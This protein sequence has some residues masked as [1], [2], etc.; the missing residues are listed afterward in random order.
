[1]TIM[2]P[3][4]KHVQSKNTQKAYILV[5]KSIKD[6]H[7]LMTTR[8]VLKRSKIDF[9]TSM[10]RIWYVENSIELRC[11]YI[12]YTVRLRHKYDFH[13]PN[14]IVRNI[15]QAA[16]TKKIKQKLWSPKPL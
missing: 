13:S 11:S 5:C 16:K 3:L 7:D 4:Q 2:D 6:T 12:R 8:W 14:D 10:K 15:T 1:M 9:Y